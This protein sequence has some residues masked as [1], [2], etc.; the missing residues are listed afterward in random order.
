[1]FWLFNT[2]PRQEKVFQN[3]FS[4]QNDGF[5]F[6]S[7]SQLSH[8]FRLAIPSLPGSA[9]SLQQPKPKPTNRNAFKR[10]VLTQQPKQENGICHLTYSLIT[11]PLDKL[12]LVH[13]FK[14]D[15]SPPPPP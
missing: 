2:L 1:M 4:L 12:W 7:N 5:C 13:S 14:K 8:L 10:K 15:Y 6:I 9:S 3:H 11:K